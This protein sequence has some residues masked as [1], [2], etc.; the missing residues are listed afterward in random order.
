MRRDSMCKTMWTSIRRRVQLVRHAICELII[1]TGGR[2]RFQLHR[3]ILPFL[4]RTHQK[5]YWNDVRLCGHFFFDLCFSFCGKFQCL[6]VNYVKY[7][8]SIW[9]TRQIFTKKIKQNETNQLTSFDGNFISK[10]CSYTHK[11][12]QTQVQISRFAWNQNENERTN[13]IINK[14]IVYMKLS[15]RNRDRSGKSDRWVVCKHRCRGRIQ[16]SM[17]LCSKWIFEF[18]FEFS[19]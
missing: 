17:E 10:A 2:R 18:H 9:Q 15:V 12:K 13:E 14:E 4:V 11:L 16:I 6:I 5:K 7:S 3:I 8:E 1:S 19:N